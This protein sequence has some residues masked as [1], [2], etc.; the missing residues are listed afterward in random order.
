MFEEDIEE[1]HQQLFDFAQDCLTL[2]KSLVLGTTTLTPLNYE[3]E[4]E[5]FFL[6]KTYNPIFTYRTFNLSPSTKTLLALHQ[7]LK[8]LTIPKE[9]KKYLKEYLEN[10]AL[11]EKTIQAVGTDEFAYYAKQLLQVK[12]FEIEKTLHTLP[13]ISFQETKESTLYDAHAIAEKFEDILESRYDI[14]TIK[15]KIDHFSDNII[16]A[17][18]KSIVIGSKVK[19]YPQNVDRLIVHEIESHVLQNYNMTLLD[20]PLLFLSH[21]HEALLFGEGIAVYNEI[22]SDTITKEAFETYYYRLKAV[23]MLDKSFREIYDY[24]VQFMSEDKAYIITYRVKR[25]MQHTEAAGGFPK[26]ASYLLG[27]QAVKNYIA[28]GSKLEFLYLAKV[29]TLLT[30]LLRHNLLSKAPVVLPQFLQNTKKDPFF[31]DPLPKEIPKVS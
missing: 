14:N 7:R 12:D 22:H 26:D 28:S 17:G 6:S 25:G 19:R 2:R 20:N 13:K 3:E 16:R 29:P 30:L 8:K 23:S 9:L 21:Y 4:R 27:Y 11:L 15:I 1:E 24:L 5:K 31:A 10:L 18:T